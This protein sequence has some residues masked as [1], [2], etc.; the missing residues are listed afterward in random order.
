MLGSKALNPRMF[1][2]KSKPDAM[3]FGSKNLGRKSFNTLNKINDVMLPAL[4]V[5]S[6]FQPELSPFFGTIGTALKGA[7]NISK[8]YKDY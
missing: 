8:H 3:F 2:N 1:G 4:T 5:G 7:Q 6:V